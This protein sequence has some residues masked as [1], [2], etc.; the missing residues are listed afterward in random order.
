[1][2][3]SEKKRKV[4]KKWLLMHSL[5]PPPPPHTHTHLLSTSNQNY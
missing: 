5:P 1:M 4:K 3:R 2:I